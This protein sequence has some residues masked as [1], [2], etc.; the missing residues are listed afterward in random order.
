MNK[1]SIVERLC[2]D[3]IAKNHDINGLLYFT[4]LYMITIPQRHGQTT[5]QT[6]RQVICH[7]N[8]AVCVVSRGKKLKT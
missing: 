4:L 7:S 2:S 5:G 1:G 6:D 3:L 8:A